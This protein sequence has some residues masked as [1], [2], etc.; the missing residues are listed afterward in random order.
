MHQGIMNPTCACRVAH[1]VHPLSQ[2]VLPVAENTSVIARVVLSRQAC[3]RTGF[4]ACGHPRPAVRDSQWCVSICGSSLS[5]V[6]LD[7]A[8]CLPTAA[9]LAAGEAVGEEGEESDNAL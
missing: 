4:R 9:G 8:G 2:I 7:S 3:R 1:A 5:R 6:P